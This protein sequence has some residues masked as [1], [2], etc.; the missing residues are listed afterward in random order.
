M[1]NIKQ[2]LIDKVLIPIEEAG[3]KAYFVGGCVRDKLMGKKPH[4]FDITTNAQPSD[5]HKIFSK[6]SNVSKNAEQFGIT[7]VL[8]PT[9][10]QGDD[11]EPSYMEVEI[12]TF[13]KDVSKGRHPEVSLEATLE[14]D[15]SRRDF[16]INA[17]YEDKDGNII[18][19]FD[20]QKDIEQKAL[21]FVG[22][23]KDRLEE[24]PLRAF[25]FVRF[26][27]KTGFTAAYDTEEIKRA[28]ESLDF[29]EV[30][31]ERML[32]EF[33]QIIAGRFFTYQS[34]AFHF[35][36][37]ARVFEV[38]G[39]LDIFSAM[40]E[41]DQAWRWHAE[42]SVFKDPEGKEF[43]VMEQR[44]FTGCT[45][46]SHGSVLA[47]TFLTFA[48]MHKIIFEGKNIPELEMEF[49]TEKIFGLKLGALLHDIGKCHCQH[50]G[51]RT[52]TF[53]FDGK[54]ILEKDIPK[55]SEHPQT[56]I[57]PAEKFCKALKMS[58]DE[59][60][61]ICS[62]VA[63]HM[64]AHELNK[65]SRFHDIL[66][67]VKHPHFKEIMMVALADERG[68][69]KLEGFDERGCVTEIMKDERVI[70]AMGM[71][72]PKPIL[73]GDDL[74]KFGRKPGPLFRKMLDVAFGIQV[75]QKITDKKML[76]KM[77]KNVELSK[78]E[79]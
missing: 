49:D 69:I 20:G 67:F 66:K 33:K 57:E 70:K 15:A 45:P 55:V 16:R 25:R 35:A 38:V 46:I 29:S 56:G 32:K 74:I 23:P 53:M 8:I 77:V 79:M 11:L 1:T 50:Q 6:F 58:N 71:E 48:E 12:A 28:C 41:I 34:E 39:L 78:E 43:L 18:D 60:H 54:E 51:I 40:D 22:N 31:K 52:K 73:T 61:L 63:H 17:M 24:D 75:D 76:Y 14:E 19:P 64:A 2:H 9:L 65:K 68:A 26:L 30:S 72:V 27:A 21:R 13:R 42:G 62:M 4:D 47:H 3:F 36:Y 59:T 10:V 37:A 7:M 5:L 44:D